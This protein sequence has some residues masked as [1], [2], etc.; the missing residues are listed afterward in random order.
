MENGFKINELF[1][2]HS[3]S[4]QTKRDKLFLDNAKANLSE[5]I[6]LLFSGT[7]D[8]KFVSEYNIKDSS[9][10]K[11]LDKITNNKYEDS[12][13]TKIDYFP[14]DS[15]YIYY[16]KNLIGRPFYKTMRNML[17]DN[18][19]LVISKQNKE[20]LGGFVSNKI[21][22]QKL[23]SAYDIN[24]TF[25]LFIYP[26][27]H[28]ELDGLTT[29][30]RIINMDRDIVNKIEKCVSSELNDVSNQNDELTP[31]NIFDYIYSII[32]QKNIKIVIMIS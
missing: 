15:P 5:R 18:L 22:G 6:K 10:Y 28:D 13:V 2:N 4:I 7:F 25:P 14:F 12:L 23:F 3:G 31:F 11:L 8:E 21:T 30:K 29:S 19:C 24:Y 20:N 16:D 1:T 32:T 17:S 27:I 26:D 9:S